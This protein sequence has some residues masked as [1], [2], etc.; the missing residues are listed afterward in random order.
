M[1]PKDFIPEGR[2][3]VGDA[4]VVPNLIGHAEQSVLAVLSR[5]HHLRLKD[6]TSKM[7][8]DG[9]KGGVEYLKRLSQ[10][11]PSARF[12]VFVLDYLTP[13]GSSI[14]HPHMQILA[15]DRPFYLVK[16][17]MEKKQ[18]LLRKQRNQLL[19]R[20]NRRG[21]KQPR[22]LFEH[23]GVDWLVPFAPLRGVEFT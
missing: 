8:F 22:Y 12:P 13:A 18:G 5:E 4:V 2:I 21:E 17:L 7:L 9:F 19:A 11:E 3:F 6:F 20:F 14:F 16:L 10:K 15:R 23:K 1:F